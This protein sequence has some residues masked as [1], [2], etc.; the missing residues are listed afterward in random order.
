MVAINIRG[1]SGS[2]K[3]TLVRNV[4]ALY[5]AKAPCLV[6][7][8]RRPHHY[9]LS[10]EG[11]RCLIVPGHYETPCGGCDTLKS[12][13]EVYELVR[14][15]VRQGSD[16][17]YEGIIVGDDT[18]YALEKPIDL[19]VIM[20]TTPIAECLSSVQARRD[21]KGTARP[22]NP[23]K[24]TTRADWIRRVTQRLEGAGVPTY[25][26]DREAAFLKVRE[27]LGV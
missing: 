2:G 7:G 24:T 5:S 25:R 22:L 11:R 16:V 3:S 20:L 9:I 21:A 13:G 6:E 10:D 19:R 17:L 8:R 15:S 4:M 27:L 26:L 23:K 12:L 1:T 14:E 18:R